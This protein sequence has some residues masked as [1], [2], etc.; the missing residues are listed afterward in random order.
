[1]G[2]NVAPVCDMIDADGG[3]NVQECLD[4]QLGDMLDAIARRIAEIYHMNDAA[5]HAAMRQ[6]SFYGVLT[7]EDSPY[8]KDTMEANFRRMQNEIEY[9]SWDSTGIF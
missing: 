6:L 8:R 2:L 4:E 9:G 1:M 3:G 5:A 7:A